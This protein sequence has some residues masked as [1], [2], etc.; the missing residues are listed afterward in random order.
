MP[1]ESQK[2]AEDHHKRN[3]EN[4]NDCRG[5]I[6]LQRQL[7]FFLGSGSQK[8]ILDSFKI[9]RNR[10]LQ[11]RSFIKKACSVMMAGYWFRITRSI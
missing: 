3:K 9:K 8:F 1:V 4:I 11:D 7:A 10:S 2:S 5:L 6:V